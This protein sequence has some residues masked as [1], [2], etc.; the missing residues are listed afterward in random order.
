MKLESKQ[1]P[2]QQTP[3]PIHKQSLRRRIACPCVSSQRPL[4]KDVVNLVTALLLLPL[5]LQL[6][7]LQARLL[8]FTQIG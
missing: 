8:S 4:T 2:E 6:S 1:H 5:P 3:V 7:V